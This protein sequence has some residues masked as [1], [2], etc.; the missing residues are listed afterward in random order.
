MKC[1]SAFFILLCLCLLLTCAAP[2]AVAQA[3]E[4][5]LYLALNVL[6][7]DASLGYTGN[8][9]GPVVEVRGDGQYTVTFDCAA[10]LSETA[11]ALGVQGLY[12]LTAIYIKDYKVT[13]GEQKTSGLAACDITW[14]QVLVN[15]QELTITKPGPKSALKSSGV[16]DT[17]DPF[18]S[19]DG[20][21]VEEASAADHVLNI[22]VENPQTVSVTFT[23][24]GL[25]FKAA[26]MPTEAPTEAPTQAPATE[27]AEAAAEAEQAGE[28]VL[29]LSANGIE[30][31]D[32]G[33]M[34][35]SLTAVEL[36]RLMGNGTNLGNTMEACN[37]GAGSVSDDPGYYETMWN[38]P[39]TT[40][41]M[42]SGMKAAGFDTL[43]IPVA[44]MTNATDLANGDFTIS[45]AYLDRVEQIINYALNADMYVI[46]N[47]HWDGGWYGMFG[48][49]SEQTRDLAMQAYTSM[50]TQIA[51]RYGEYS[52]RLIFEG[53]NEEIGARF[54][55]NS[56]L[57][58]SDSIQTYFTDDE[59]YEL[60]NR[61]NQVFV[62]TVRATGGNNAQ[63]FL[64]IPGF[65]TNIDNTLD[66]RFVMPTDSAENKLMISVHF[67]D[68]W[69]YCGDGQ[70]TVRW[71]TVS[72]YETMM[73]TLQKMTRFVDEGYG[74]VIGEYGVL[75]ATELQENTVKYHQAF[76]DCCDLY[77][78]TNCLWDC[79]AFFRRSELAMVDKDLARLY[80]KRNVEAQELMNVEELGIMATRRLNA[81]LAEAPE[82]FRTD[83]IANGSD[84][85]VA[86][87]MWNSADY[88]TTYS[89][90]DERNTDSI[91]QGVKE[92]DVE[93]TGEGDYTVAL[94]FTGTAQGYSAG[95]AFSALAVSNGELL[96]PGYVMEIQEIL[97][98]GEP[99]T[100]SGRPYTTSDN[101]I[102][103]RVNLFN[104]WVHKLPEEARTLDGDLT[105][106]TPCIID[107]NDEVISRIETISITF[108]YGP[109]NG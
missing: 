21:A 86:W 16:F 56:P 103:T 76:L 28:R 46:V 65:G 9:T 63:R 29:H 101:R 53:A 5:V 39:V 41:E 24:S 87:I 100:L 106:C 34:R 10:D 67:Y 97:I 40:Q 81:L 26:E 17:N 52:D 102:T 32:D 70:S 72:D 82:S 98:N 14:D 109:A 79:S 88:C 55:E 44:W 93:I 83:V 68:P 73:Q 74:V 18:N 20:S 31:Y 54:D 90:G 30:T 66:A 71:G 80:G 57:Y 38:Q 62:D 69:A 42:I 19:W 37:S 27:P 60:A 51:N 91:T 61:I 75:Y 4:P 25:T 48:S 7:N 49:E 8:E 78:Y 99:Y 89:V 47:D 94:D 22:H 1:K 77:N 23:L 92:T 33:V 59:K 45:E 3:E 96:F 12:N 108:H 50:W 104:E 64:L 11:V 2:A 43:R 35:T 84:K 105:G 6:Y 107:R 85:A 36:T 13:L 58:C 95:I 15:G